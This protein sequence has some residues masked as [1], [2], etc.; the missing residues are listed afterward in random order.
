[1]DG[2]KKLF[3]NCF[4][5]GRRGWSRSYDVKFQ[6]NAPPYQPIHGIWLSHCTLSGILMSAVDRP[7]ITCPA[8]IRAKG[9]ASSHLSRQGQ[10]HHRDCH[11]MW[12]F[13]ALISKEL[14]RNDCGSCIENQLDP[15]NA[16]C[17]IPG[18]GAASR[19]DVGLVQL[20]HHTT[21]TLPSGQRWASPGPL[22]YCAGIIPAGCH[23][24]QCSWL[25][26]AAAC[27]WTWP[28]Q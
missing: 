23:L 18:K 20:R 9:A 2:R 5:H 22:M 14:V 3:W 11:P 7:L 13:S 25:L 27:Q 1:M 24:Y 10:P 28:R 6:N 19:M 15:W 21:V 17:Y 26:L 16:P 4:G 8:D 12:E